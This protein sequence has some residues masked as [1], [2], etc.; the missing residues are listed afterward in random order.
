MA[1]MAI[2]VLVTG[3]I[4]AGKT[5]LGEALSS[6]EFKVAHVKT[7]DELRRVTEAN[8]DTPRHVLSASGYKLDEEKPD[9][10]ANAI[11][12]AMLNERTGIAYVDCIRSEKQI[13]VL[14]AALPE[15]RFKVIHVHLTVGHVDVVTQRARNRNRKGDENAEVTIYGDL[16]NSERFHSLADVVID[17]SRLDTADMQTIVEAHI[18]RINGSSG[19]ASV[20]VFVGAQYGSEGKGNVIARIAQNYDVLCRVGGPNAGHSVLT[21]RDSQK[22]SFY[23]IPSGV[24]H[25]TGPCLIGPG[26]VINPDVLAKELAEC[27]KHGVD[28]SERLLIDRAA[29]IITP[30]MIE[31]ETGGVAR[32]GSTGQGV[33]EATIAKLRR[34]GSATLAMNHPQFK[35]MCGDTREFLDRQMSRGARVMM[36]GTQGTGLDIHHGFYPYV[37][38][39]GTQASTTCGEMGIGP[40]HINRV[41]MVTR[42]N[43]IRVQSPEGGTSGYIGRELSWE[44]ISERCGVDADKLRERERT[45]TTKRLRRVAEFDFAWLRRASMLN[46]PTDI[47]LTFV[48]YY[49]GANKDV[50]RWENLTAATRQFIEHIEVVA[51]ASVSMVSTGFAR[52]SF[53]DRRSIGW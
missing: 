32:I 28:M 41:I 43:P 50:T 20:D 23:H 22:V 52:T 13:E 48:D 24:L 51:G 12:D 17:S 4:C 2:L 10:L 35:D 53:I 7:S 25:S 6:G 31:A 8:E 30:E 33:G 42:T 37:T 40:M 36:E 21:P 49:D 29:V 34:N 19:R 18:R 45:T 15:P 1:R 14:R 46:S 27:F 11:K 16:L 47:A 9:W 5:T 39:R 44:D 26:A 3:C 38:S